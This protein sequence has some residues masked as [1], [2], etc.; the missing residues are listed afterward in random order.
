[1][2]QPI[3]TAPRDRIIDLWCVPHDDCDFEPLDD[4]IRLTDVLWHDADEHSDKTG[5]MRVCDDGNWDFVEYPACTPLG[6]PP[7]KPTHWMDIPD[8]P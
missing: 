4:G 7:W 2:W 5:W 6:L 1:M 3:E 8:G